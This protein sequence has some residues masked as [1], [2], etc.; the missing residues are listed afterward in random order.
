MTRSISIVAA[1]MICGLIAG[2][3]GKRRSMGMCMLCMGI[4]IFLC[5][6]MPS[7]AW[8]LPCLLLFPSSMC[9][10][11]VKISYTVFV[12]ELMGN[13]WQDKYPLMIERWRRRSAAHL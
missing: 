6:L 7:Y 13:Y 9:I 5:A 12:R 11:F 2:R 8:L 1:L 3:I 10:P 4:G